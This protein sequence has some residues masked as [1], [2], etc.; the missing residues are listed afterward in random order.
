M[1]SVTISLLLLMKQ[2]KMPPSLLMRLSTD[3]LLIIEIEILDLQV[4]SVESILLIIV[5]MLFFV[6]VFN[7][8]SL[9]L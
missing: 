4:L 9:I 6:Y 1:E 2:L 5:S 8:L 3:N 7:C